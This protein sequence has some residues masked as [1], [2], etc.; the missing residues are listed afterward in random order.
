MQQWARQAT[1]GKDR[2]VSVQD[3]CAVNILVVWNKKYN[4]SLPFSLS[5]FFGYSLFHCRIYFL[6]Q[7]P[8]IHER[9]VKEGPMDGMYV[10]LMWVK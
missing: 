3:F 2:N 1:C 6:T 7:E 5:C 10:D 4:I 8:R 9:I